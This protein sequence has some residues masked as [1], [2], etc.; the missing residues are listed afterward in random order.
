MHVT[1]IQNLLLGTTIGDAFGAGVEF[2]DRHWIRQNVDFSRFINA[3]STIKLPAGHQG[4]FTKNYRAWDYTDDT[5]MTVGIIKAL[6]SNQPFTPDLL[7]QYWLEEYQ[8]GIQR[9]GVGRHGHGSMAWFYEGQMSMEALRDF[10]RNRPNPGNAP[11]MR[12][13]P[14]GLLDENL[15]N[16]Y[17]AI[18]ANATHPNEAAVL[19]SQCV[20]RAAQYLLVQNGDP[21][22]LLSYCRDTLDLNAEYLA[23]F[24]QLE[25]LPPFDALDEAAFARLCGPQPIM[26]PYFLPG[27]HGL[28]S[29]SKYTAGCVLYVLKHSRTA[30][31]ALQQSVRLGGDV[32]SLASITTGILGA[33][34]GLDTLPA[35]MLEQVEGAVYLGTVAAQFGQYL[36]ARTTD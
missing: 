20:A 14:L 15:V 19:S 3:R 32:D 9:K 30:L 4:D 24:A 29:D 2:Q 33:L 28:P 26:E 16:E 1:L 17:A 31:E 27:I 12:A 25:Q 8:S 21:A 5:E 22:Q 18:N 6:C 11:A 7:V 23:C 35:F 10:Q 13:V 34:D 36:N